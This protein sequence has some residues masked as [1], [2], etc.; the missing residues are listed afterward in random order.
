MRFLFYISQNYSFEILRPLQTEIFNRGLECAW[1]VEG[2]KVDQS[3]FDNH[4][5]RLESIEDVHVYSPDA[6]F[7][8]GNIVPNFIPGIKVQVFH[9]FEWKKKGHFRIRGCFDLYC[10]QGPFFTE[11]F[12]QLRENYKHFNVVETGWPKIDRLHNSESYCWPG[13]K[14]LPIILF[15]PTFS[16]SLSSAPAL[17]DEIKR[18][19]KAENWQWLIK[20]HPKMDKQWVEKYRQLEGPN[21]HIVDYGDIAPLLTVADVMVSDTSSIITEFGLLAKPIVSFNNSAPEDHLL[22]VTQPGHLEKAVKKALRA[23]NKW[24]EKIEKNLAQ[25]H[26]YKDGKSSKRVLD[27]TIQ[28][29]ANNSIDLKPKPSNLLRT[30]KLRKKLK[31]WQF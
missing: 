23:E 6:V 27:A 3:Y 10:T 25:M 11:K 9:G 13:K 8:P 26:P 20:F 29:V 30:F 16:P 7:V 22:N 2:T 31:Y 5:K 19:R 15:A 17:Y 1:F 28:H 24:I 18:L 4:E 14:S 21:L 12:K